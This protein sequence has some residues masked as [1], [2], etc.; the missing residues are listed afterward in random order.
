MGISFNV[1]LTEGNAKL[2]YRFVGRE[3]YKGSPQ[4][5][6]DENYDT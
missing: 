2:C 1:P 3:D 5:S 6:P 4:T